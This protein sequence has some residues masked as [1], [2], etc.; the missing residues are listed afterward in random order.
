MSNADMLAKAYNL[1]AEAKSVAAVAYASEQ[2]VQK[3]KDIDALLE[4]QLAQYLSE[5]LLELCNRKSAVM[6]QP[7]TIDGGIPQS[8]VVT[9]Y[10]ADAIVMHPDDY[11]SLVELVVTLLRSARMDAT[12]ELP[13]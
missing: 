12:T 5:P 4:R 13:Q 1:L 8:R 7:I 3:C 11:S 6:V 10:R 2:Q 9:A